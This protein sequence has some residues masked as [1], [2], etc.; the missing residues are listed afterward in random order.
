MKQQSI[1]HLIAL[2]TVAIWGTTF[3]STKI[4]AKICGNT[5]GGMDMNRLIEPVHKNARLRVPGE[6]NFQ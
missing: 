6:C 3:I 4:C 2:I 5:K 1:G